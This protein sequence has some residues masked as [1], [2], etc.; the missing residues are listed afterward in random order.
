MRVREIW[1]QSRV[2]IMDEFWTKKRP[3]KRAIS[4]QT[5]VLSFLNVRSLLAF[6]AISNIKTYTFVFFEALVASVY[7]CREVSE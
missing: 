1:K 7:N 3:D 6:W 5:A 2:L 4:N